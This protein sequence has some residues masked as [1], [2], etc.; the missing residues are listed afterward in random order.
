[1]RVRF[2]GRRG[3][4]VPGRVRRRIEETEALTAAQPPAD[5]DVRVQLRR[6]GRDRRRGAR[7]RARRRPPAGS[8][9]TKIDE[10]TIARHLYAPDMPD[11][12]LLVRTSGEYRISNYLLWE[13]AYSELVFTDV[14]WPDFRTQR[15]RRRHRRVPTPRPPLRRHLAPKPHQQ[16]ARN[17][18][19]ARTLAT[20]GRQFA[21]ER[22]H[23]VR[24]AGELHWCNAGAVSGRGGRAADDQARRGR[25]HRH[26]PHPGARQGA[27]GGQ[28]RPQDVEP[29]RRPARAD[30]PGR[31]AVLPRPRA[32][33]RHPG[34]D[35]RGEPGAARGVRVAHARDPDARS[36]RPGRAGARAE[37]GA[38]P[39][40]HRRA[41]GARRAAE[42]GRHVRVLL[43]AAVARGHPSDARRL[44]PLRRDARRATT[45]PSWSRS[46]STR[47]ARCAGRAR[48]AAAGRCRTAA[49]DLLRRMLGGGLERRVRASRPARRRTRSNSS[50]SVPSSTT[51]SAACAPPRCSSADRRRSGP[52][53]GGP[54][55]S[56]A[57]LWQ[58]PATP[59]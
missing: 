9:P 59:S 15:P 45:T 58:P 18:R 56:L 29:V 1:M 49:L 48:A 6:P 36:R 53:N 37:P 41:A 40:A 19:A 3:G 8:I 28:G 27:G 31:A 21:T 35:A 5:A 38:L 30:E 14:L 47:A 25:P 23:C 32:R 12:D 26:G 10:R 22:P 16:L 4:R 57:C 42:P 34:R 46:I 55:T 54:P 11:P 17:I 39:H 33:R 13:L 20:V 50:A 7:D 24:V 2:I 51:S 43:E 44:R 52:G